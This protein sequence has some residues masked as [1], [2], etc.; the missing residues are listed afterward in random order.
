M[1]DWGKGILSQQDFLSDSIST[2]MEDIKGD[3]DFDIAP[4]ISTQNM[5]LGFD[6]R[7]DVTLSGSLT[8]SLEAALIGA[9][10]SGVEL[11]MSKNTGNAILSYSESAM[12]ASRSRW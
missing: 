1:R 5:D 11:R 12:R 8:G 10:S 3:I 6:A 2:M 9:L 4:A 7:G